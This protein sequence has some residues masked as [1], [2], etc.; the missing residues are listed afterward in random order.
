MKRKRLTNDQFDALMAEC[1]RRAMAEPPPDL[2][3]LLSCSSA[4]TKEDRAELAK[5]TPT[6]VRKIIALARKENAKCQ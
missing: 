2:S 6:R 4:L 1:F 3:D 5:I